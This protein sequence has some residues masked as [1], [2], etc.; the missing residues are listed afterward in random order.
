MEGKDNEVNDIFYDQLGRLV[1]GFSSCD[2]KVIDGDLN[3]KKEKE[4]IL[5]PTLL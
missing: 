1:D 3:A 2:M 5:R 4:E